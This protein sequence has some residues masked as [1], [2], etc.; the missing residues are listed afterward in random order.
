MTKSF[1]RPDGA[2]FD[3]VNHLFTW[4][5]AVAGLHEVIF[6][7]DDGVMTEEMTVLIDVK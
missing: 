4:T 5:G 6:T 1:F 3:P 2:S 7:V